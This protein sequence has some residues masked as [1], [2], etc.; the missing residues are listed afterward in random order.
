[1]REH[2]IVAYYENVE[3]VMVKVIHVSASWTVSSSVSIMVIVAIASLVSMTCMAAEA[4]V[5][6]VSPAIA[7]ALVV[8]T[9]VSTEA[10]VCHMTLAITTISCFNQSKDCN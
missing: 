1:M 4:L 5:V 2:V 3:L 10:L 9:C 8:M 6:H 7:M